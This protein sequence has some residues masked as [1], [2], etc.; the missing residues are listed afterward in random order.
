MKQTNDSSMILNTH[1]E[2]KKK[3]KIEIDGNCL[4]HTSQLVVK[5]TQIEIYSGI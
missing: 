3:R 1:V 2:K 4:L 5:L